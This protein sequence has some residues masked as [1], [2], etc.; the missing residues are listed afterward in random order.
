MYATDFPSG[1]KENGVGEGTAAVI[2]A[3]KSA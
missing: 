1:V 2:S 3:R